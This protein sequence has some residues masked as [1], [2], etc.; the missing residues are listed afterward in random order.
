MHVVILESEIGYQKRVSLLSSD[1]LLSFQKVSPSISEFEWV[2][3]WMESVN[4]FYQLRL[5]M[6]QNV[7]DYNEML[8]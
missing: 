6:G 7:F 1:V 2:W 3:I 4:F 8:G 5:V